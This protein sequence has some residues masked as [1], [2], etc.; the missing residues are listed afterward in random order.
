[1]TRAARK[2]AFVLSATDHGTLIVNR[3]DHHTQKDG[4]SIGVGYHLLEACACDP[5]EVAAEVGLLEMARQS[6]GPG[7]VAWDCGANIGVHTVEWAR[8]MSGWGRSLPSSLRS[9]FF[10][11][12]RATL[13]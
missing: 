5:A 10:T 4:V 11:P 9:G 8:A 13:R 2:A 7:V 1:M 3:F 6:R 12:W